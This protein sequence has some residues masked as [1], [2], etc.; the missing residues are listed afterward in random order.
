MNRQEHLL[1]ILSEEC[2]EVTQSVTKSL[3]FGLDDFWKDSPV[4]R[5]K[6][7]QEMGDLL[8][9]FFMLVGEGII[10]APAE[11]LISAKREKIEKFLQYARERGTLTE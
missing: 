9:I 4:N 10:D 8:G 7:T 1:T 6:I 2:A 11:S 5:D 3:R